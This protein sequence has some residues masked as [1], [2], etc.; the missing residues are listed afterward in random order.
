[1]RQNTHEPL[2][3][4]RWRR[5]DVRPAVLQS[6]GSAIVDEALV[7]GSRSPPNRFESGEGGHDRAREMGF[8]PPEEGLQ[9]D[10]FGE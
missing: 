3:S 9:F 1:M 2:F 5:M 8:S 4:A 6:C 7:E 10:A